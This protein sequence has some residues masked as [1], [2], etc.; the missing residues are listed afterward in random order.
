MTKI[1]RYTYVPDWETIT[2]SY[3]GEYVLYEDYVE[4]IKQFLSS[5]L[6]EARWA[7]FLVQKL[8]KMDESRGNAYIRFRNEF[9]KQERSKKLNA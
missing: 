1:K 2:E 5:E 9:D 8:K 7:H 3:D 6:K 4:V